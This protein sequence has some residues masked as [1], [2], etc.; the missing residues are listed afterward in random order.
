M[1]GRFQIWYRYSLWLLAIIPDVRAHGNH[2]LI[3]QLRRNCLNNVDKYYK[4]WFCSLHSGPIN[5]EI[6]PGSLARV[7]SLEYNNRYVF[8][9]FL[10]PRKYFRPHPKH[11]TEHNKSRF[12]NIFKTS[13]ILNDSK[14]KL[15]SSLAVLNRLSFKMDT[16]IFC[17]KTEVGD[18]KYVKAQ[19]L[20]SKMKSPKRKKHRRNLTF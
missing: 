20:Q 4:A 12:L 19:F 6:A 2:N 14:K 11:R 13:G 5:T 16:E 15:D 1:K 8:F 7:H 3:M 10:G 18:F 9:I 17:F